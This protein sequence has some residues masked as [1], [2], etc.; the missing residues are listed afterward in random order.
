MGVQRNDTIKGIH[1][2]GV[3]RNDTIKGSH[4]MGVKCDDRTFIENIENSIKDSIVLLDLHPLVTKPAISL[5]LTL[6]L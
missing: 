5:S 2:I 3:Q 1:G 6:L 4:E